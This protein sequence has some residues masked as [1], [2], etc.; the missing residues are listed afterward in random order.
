MS[1]YSCALHHSHKLPPLLSI[2]THTHTASSTLHA[3]PYPVGL[4]VNCALCTSTSG[5]T[6][7]AQSTIHS[8]NLLPPHPLIPP[9]AAMLSQVLFNLI[10]QPQTDGLPWY[11]AIDL[12]IHL[13]LQYVTSILDLKWDLFLISIGGILLWCELGVQNISTQ[14]RFCNINIENV[15]KSMQC[16]F[17]LWRDAGAALGTGR[18]AFFHVTWGGARA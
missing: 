5:S 2:H 18:P 7:L 11:P 13:T 6:P 15:P 10:H 4:R 9:T 8:M 12:Q 14:Y 17:V 3:L 16:I 1:S